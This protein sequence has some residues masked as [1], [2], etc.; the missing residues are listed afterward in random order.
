[1]LGEKIFGEESILHEGQNVKIALLSIV[2][3]ILGLCV[4]FTEGWRMPIFLIIMFAAVALIFWKPY[5]GVLFLMLLLYFAPEKHGVGGARIVLYVSF[6]VLIAW[7]I[8]GI[9]EKKL[10]IKW[11]AQLVIMGILTLW[12]FIITMTAHVSVLTSWTASTLFLKMF[13]LCFL[14]IALINSPKRL[15]IAIATNLFGITYFALNGFYSFLTGGDA[16]GIYSDNNNLAHFL[17][18]C[19]PF[20]IVMLFYPAKWIKLWGS[21][22]L[23]MQ[24]CTL[25]ISNSRGGM[26][27][28]TGVLIWM[29]FQGVRE[30]KWKMMGII[31]AIILF[32][33]VIIFGTEAGRKCIKRVETIQTYQQDTGS[34]MKRIFLW[35]TGIEMMKDYPITGVGPENFILTF[36][37]YSPLKA[38]STHSTYIQFGSECGIPGLGL[39]LL[40]LLFHFKTMFDIKKRVDKNSSTAYCCLALEAGFI[41]HLIASTFLAKMYFEPMYW[42]IMFGAIL[43]ILVKAGML[44]KE[45]AGYHE[46]S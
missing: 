8:N 28:L 24:L 34:S 39:Y 19:F 14:I 17:V 16:K 4:I 1:M 42:L 15:K 43:K 2:G 36:P 31:G 23:L 29:L 13:M 33:A 30:F 41:G 9:K 25:I 26:L 32:S 45:A 3:V 46:N 22:L 35:Q 6:L 12:M 40:L 7:L 21:G 5:T 11:P 10:N 18:L 44:N 38:Q 20:A 37:E 27:G